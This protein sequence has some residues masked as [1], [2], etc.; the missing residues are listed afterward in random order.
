MLPRQLTSVSDY[1]PY[2]FWQNKEASLAGVFDMARQNS[3][4]EMMVPN[5][6]GIPVH[7][8]HGSDDDNVPAYHSRLMYQLI[9]ESG[10]YSKYD[11]L[12]GKG[13]WFDG[14]LT[15]DPLV[16]FY[17][18]HANANQDS[19]DLLPL[20]FSFVVPPS[21]ELASRG[22]LVV[23]QLQSPD[24]YGRIHVVR[25]VN[26]RAWRLR[27]SNVRR[28]HLL[29]QM[30]RAPYPERL[31]IDDD[32]EPF[33]IPLN[34]SRCTWLVR[35]NGQWRR[36]DESWLWGLPRQRYGEQ[37]GN[38]DAILRTTGPFE[39]VSTSSVANDL[40]LQISRNL[41]QY[42][43]ADSHIIPAV[44]SSSPRPHIGSGNI[45]ALYL[46][47]FSWT[48]MN[49]FPIQLNYYRQLLVK[50]P[51]NDSADGIYEFESGLG[52]IFLQPVH[53][54]RLELVLWGADLAG[55]QHAARLVPMLTGTGQPDFVVT[56]FRCR[57]TG[58][59][60]IY[61]AGFFDHSWR[62]SMGSYVS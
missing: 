33:V 6:A 55:L 11:E 60:G 46:G 36:T 8:Q 20:E 27:T 54:E 50:R 42:Y 15:T 26:S 22:G 39:I 14:V 52:A 13:H 34:E 53:D 5:F 1:V 30:I 37:V 18:R 44:T 9:K 56:C 31:F 38:I 16:D 4:H 32:L 51:G 29:H 41:F 17:Q 19:N 28:F 59:G 48:P 21:A 24:R 10:A 45:I 61:A 49:D 3:K 25:D 7:Q 35:L 2:T 57:R 12:P 47:N 58:P 62:V 43:S 40:A 23:D